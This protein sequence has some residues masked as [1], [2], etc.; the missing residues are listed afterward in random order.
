M[1]EPLLIG[2]AAWIA[3]TGTA[4]A[5]HDRGV[6][7][8]RDVHFQGAGQ[9]FNDGDELAELTGSVI[10]N[11]SVSSVR[12]DAGCR[13]TLYAD[14]HFRGEAITLSE[15]VDDLRHTYF[16]NDRA[17]SLAVECRRPGWFDGD[18]SADGRSG[19]VLYTD[20]DFRGREEAVHDDDRDLRDNPV[21]QDTVSSVRVAPGCR[22]VLYADVDFRGASTLLTDSAPSLAGTAVGNDRVSSLE[23]SCDGRPEGVTLYEDVSY[24]GRAETFLRDDPQLRDNDIREDRVSSARVAPGCVATLYEHPGYRGRATT[25]RG[26]EPDLRRTSVGNDSVSS[27]RVDC[28][29]FRR[30]R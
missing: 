15:D 8:Y 17:S 19:A 30:R 26:D 28:R 27:I 9:T 6:T 13:V 2:L 18:P 20:Q 21:G 10:G 4:V 16:G 5:D 12:V 29:R 3:L 23:V 7:L 22:V 24:A 14:A 1:R 25:L 11:D